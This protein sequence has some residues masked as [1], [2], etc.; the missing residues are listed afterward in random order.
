MVEL[1]ELDVPFR[2]WERH[3]FF[4]GFNSPACET[5]SSI[6][7]NSFVVYSQRI[8][9]ITTPKNSLSM[10]N[11]PLVMKRFGYLGKHI[12]QCCSELHMSNI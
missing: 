8:L 7:P 6:Q 3:R 2:N 5:F 4:S 11:V 10:G 9:F 12:N 1:P